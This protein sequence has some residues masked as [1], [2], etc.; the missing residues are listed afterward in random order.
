MGRGILKDTMGRSFLLTV[1]SFLLTVG[2]FL[3]TVGLGCLRLNLFGLSY[4]R[5]KFSSVFFAYGKNSV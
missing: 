5:L 4:L 1:G 2:S 3:L